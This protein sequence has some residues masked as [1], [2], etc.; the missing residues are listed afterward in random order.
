VSNDAGERDV[1]RDHIAFYE[2][3]SEDLE[4]LTW[5]RPGTSV[6]AVRYVRHY[7]V[8]MVWGDLYEATYMWNY[9]PKFCM[10]WIG[11]C[12]LDYFLGKCRASPHGREPYVWDSET[13]RKNLREYFAEFKD[14]KKF[15]PDEYAEEIRQRAEEEQQFDDSCG[16]NYLDDGEFG[17]NHWSY[18]NGYE[19][20]GDDWYENRTLFAPG[21]ELDFSIKL[22]YEGLMAAL[23]QLKEKRNEGPSSP[24][25]G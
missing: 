1:F 25:T 9:E 16:W 21:K 15:D 17:Y 5:Q 20:F 2:A 7:G 14:P 18:D 4:T 10:E 23:K 3:H 12:S 13:A 22:H 11:G 6:Y 8:L 24:G 19:I